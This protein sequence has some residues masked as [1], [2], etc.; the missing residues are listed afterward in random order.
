MEKL[1]HQPL[2]S[3]SKYP[4]PEDQASVIPRGDLLC[5]KFINLLKS[6]ISNPKY[7][8][9]SN[10]RNSK[11]Q[12]MS[13]LGMF[14]VIEYWNLRFICNLVLEI[15]DFRHKTPKQSHLSLTP[16]ER[17]FQLAH[18]RSRDSGKDQVFQDK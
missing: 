18:R 15:C 17:D 13:R 9:I 3:E 10:D 2:S 1:K 12:T 5:W 16:A 8:T 11:I 4:G 6:Q 14:L 7:Q